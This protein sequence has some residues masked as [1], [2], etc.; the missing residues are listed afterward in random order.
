MVLSK[1]VG[2][3]DAV[4]LAALNLRVKLSSKDLARQFWPGQDIA[5]VEAELDDVLRLARLRCTACPASYPFEVS[6]RSISFKDSVGFNTYLFLLL[7]RALDFGG[8]ENNPELQR[9]F[10]HFFEDV[11][12]WAMR[13]SAF[14]AEVLSIPREPRGLHVQLA[15]ALRQIAMRFGEPAQLR[16]DRLA[17]NDNDLDVDVLAVP[18]TGNGT[19]GGWPVFQIQC[20][21]GKIDR[22]EAKTS[23]GAQTFC[24]VWENGFYPGCRVRGAATPDDLLSLDIIYWL[25]LGQAGWII[26]RTRI[27]Y[28][29]SGNTDVPLPPDLSAFW[30]E[31]WAAKSDITWQTGWQ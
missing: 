21:T 3:C 2:L 8:P 22:L 18:R 28:L 17:A 31:I 7:G 16:E 30:D 25:R 15:P 14:A 6:E 13:K 1:T 5:E 26:D 23:E 11:V 20:A 4:E 24:T 9:K 27:A 19:L 29:A 10:R 12:C